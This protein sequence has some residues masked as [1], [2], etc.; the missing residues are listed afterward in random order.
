MI[1]SLERTKRESWLKLFDKWVKAGA[2][3]LKLEKRWTS[4]RIFWSKRFHAE[5]K[6]MRITRSFE[7]RSSASRLNRVQTLVSLDSVTRPTSTILRRN[8]QS[9]L[10]DQ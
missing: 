2:R 5:S 8:A 9:R 6:L 10:R 7:R 3:M 1:A 4:G